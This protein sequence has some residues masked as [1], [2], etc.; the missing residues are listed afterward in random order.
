MT[1]FAVLIVQYIF[2]KPLPNSPRKWEALHRNN[3]QSLHKQPDSS[4]SA[5]ATFSHKDV[6]PHSIFKSMCKASLIRGQRYQ[7][8]QKQNKNN[9]RVTQRE[10]SLVGLTGLHCWKPI[11]WAY[12]THSLVYAY[13]PTCSDTEEFFILC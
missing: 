12:P 5:V 4:A 7:S 9:W 11:Y 8:G 3:M 10:S 6:E 13:K 1:S 2:M